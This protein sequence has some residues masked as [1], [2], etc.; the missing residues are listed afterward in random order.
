MHT[1]AFQIAK[2]LPKIYA[3]GPHWASV[4]VPGLD[5]RISYSKAGFAYA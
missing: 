4:A 3:D 2:Q 1:R 5:V